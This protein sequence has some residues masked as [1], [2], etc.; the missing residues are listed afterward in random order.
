MNLSLK[1]ILKQL[2]VLFISEY[3][4]SCKKIDNILKIFFRNTLY[5]N[6]PNYAKELYEKH[7]PSILVID[8]DL[9]E[10]KGIEFIKE[11]RKKNNSIP[12]LVIT[13]NK[14][15][16]NLLEAIKLNLVDYLLK[17]L[18]INILIYSLNIC[19][20][21]LLNT[22]KVK[23]IIKEKI[24]Y[25]YVEKSIY[26]PNSKEVLT[27]N[28]ARLIEFFL[29]NKNKY[30]TKDDIKRYIWSHEEISESAFKSLINRLSKKAGKDTINNSFGVGYGIF[31]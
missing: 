21:Q 3:D 24:K 12:I 8:I 26:H 5:T 14:E 18:D 29:S 16:N 10:S 27:K 19:A 11:L 22:G 28:E 13:R 25:N 31:D 4:E 23:T 1:N 17:P 2:D 15:L 30:L 9:K 20:K 7:Y 6:S